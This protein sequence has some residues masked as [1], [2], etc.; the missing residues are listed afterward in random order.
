[1]EKVLQSKQEGSIPGHCAQ[2]GLEPNQG[3]E[4][5]GTRIQWNTFYAEIAQVV[6]FECLWQVGSMLK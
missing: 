4:A 3:T 2:Q 6:S 1:M 5:Q